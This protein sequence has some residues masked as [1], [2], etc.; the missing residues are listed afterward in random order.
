MEKFPPS[1]LVISIS[2]C[3]VLIFSLTDDASSDCEDINRDLLR[4]ISIPVEVDP[5]RV[6]CELDSRDLV[7]RLPLVPGAPTVSTSACI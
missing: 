7:L 5:A 4:V 3:S 2:A 1:T 6:T